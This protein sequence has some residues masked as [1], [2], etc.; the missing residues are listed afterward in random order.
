VTNYDHIPIQ[1]SGIDA[2]TDSS[3]SSVESWQL[4]AGW[5][6]LE[7][8][9]SADA[10]L[11]HLR[12]AVD[13]SKSP[14]PE[15]SLS[16][17]QV[18]VDY[19][20]A[21]G[22]V[23]HRADGEDH[24]FDF[25]VPFAQEYEKKPVNA[26]A[27]RDR[28]LCVQ[29]WSGAFDFLRVTGPFST[30]SNRINLKE[31]ERWQEFTKFIL[32]KENREALSSALRDGNGSGDSAEVLKALT[33]LYPSSFFDGAQ[34][35]QE[36]LKAHTE[37]YQRTLTDR[38][39]REAEETPGERARRLT[40]E[41]I[42]LVMKAQIENGQQ[43]AERLKA[44]CAWFRRPPENACSIRWVPKG[45]EEWREALELLKAGRVLLDAGVRP[46]FEFSLPRTA[47]KPVLVIEAQC[48][49][50]AIAASIYADYW[51]GV[52]YKKC[53]ECGTVFRLGAG[54]RIG[55]WQEKEHCS[56]KCKQ[57]GVNR[58]RT[59]KMGK[60]ALRPALG[61]KPGHKSGAARKG[62]KV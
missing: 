38:F 61:S 58:N 40:P 51:D 11:K 44:L 23:A 29:G 21:P 57:A 27:L 39:I 53:P 24:I 13:V 26:F 49:L 2:E 17:M 14:P 33:G 42:A 15:R 54:K 37:P 50:H 35:P 1:M 3:L 47:L 22:S 16:A 18:I 8:A 31:F 12:E 46:A 10:E 25:E 19:R 45:P 52:E 60:K 48:S 28:F 55:R 34:I 20:I 62:G 30:V 7:A 6:A 41:E 56:E 36:V 5:S 32:V 59:K 43:R 4:E 9:R